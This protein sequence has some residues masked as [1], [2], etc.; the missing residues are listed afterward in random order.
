MLR[1]LIPSLAVLAACSEQPAG[2]SEYFD[3]VTLS[4]LAEPSTQVI[5]QVTPAQTPLSVIT[6]QAPQGTDETLITSLSAA[7]ENAENG[8]L[9]SPVETGAGGVQPLVVID[10]TQDAPGSVEIDGSSEAIS[11]NSFSSVTAERSIDDDRARTEALSQQTVVLEAQ[12]VPQVEAGV[13][14]A[15]FARATTHRIGERKFD[16]PDGS[17]SAARRTCRKYPNPDAAQRAFL[18]AGGPQQDDLKIDPDGDGFVCGWSPLPYR[19]LSI[20]Q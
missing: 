6:E 9:T 3:I 10:G 18:A 20:G 15:A 2:Q 14:L 17:K 12:P 8:T 4:D 16:R 11:D 19:N 13:N 1:Y 5:Q 7:I